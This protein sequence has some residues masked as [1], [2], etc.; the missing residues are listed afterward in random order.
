MP[1]GKA[2]ATVRLSSRGNVVGRDVA[3]GYLMTGF[4][5]VLGINGKA[6]RLTIRRSQRGAWRMIR[7]DLYD[8]HFTYRG[9]LLREYA[10]ICL[11]GFKAAT[12]MDLQVGDRFSV[13]VKVIK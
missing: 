10:F 6:V 9:K 5:K 1:K 12:G 8:A 4:R 13:D 3:D 2:R 7:R 11:D